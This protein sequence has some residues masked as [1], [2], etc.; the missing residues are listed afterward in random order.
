L[1]TGRET[2]PQRLKPGRHSKYHGTAQAVPLQNRRTSN[3]FSD[4]TAK[5]SHGKHKSNRRH[6]RAQETETCGTKEGRPQSE[7]H[8]SARLVEEEGP[9]ADSRAEQALEA[10]AGAR[11][12]GEKPPKNQMG[13]ANFLSSASRTSQRDSAEGGFMSYLFFLDE[14][15]H[16]HKGCPYEVRGGIVLH[17]SRLWRFVQD[18]ATLEESCFGVRLS[19][20]RVEIK[21]SFLLAKN[22]FRWASQGSLLDDVARRKYCISFLNKGLQHSSPS[23]IEF[24]AFGQACLAMARAIFALL[25]THE[26]RIFASV[27]PATVRKPVT[28]QAED[29][30]RR[31][32]VFLLER[33]FNF[34]TPENETGILVF[35]ET[36]AAEDQKFIRQIERYFTRT[37]RGRFRATSIVPVPFFVQSDLTRAVQA[38]DL[39]IYATNWGFRLPKRGMDALVR[40]EIANEFGPWIL[41]SQA[42]GFSA[43]ESGSFQWFSIVFVP[44]PFGGE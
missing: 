6:D 38:A 21:G 1:L 22:K 23:E 32:M 31:D 14:S 27:V 43:D 35:D 28:P 20:F 42:E 8:H 7:A 37:Q 34:I 3:A 39:C 11:Q 41:N 16:D 40:K 5:D 33:Y 29:Y 2:V 24:R 17:S 13:L 15:G 4:S 10:T 19:E 36:D 44:A 25:R 30:L 9:E 26:A 12:T 18:F